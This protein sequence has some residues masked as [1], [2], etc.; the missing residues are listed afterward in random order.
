MVHYGFFID[1]L[2]R[3]YNYRLSKDYRYAVTKKWNWCTPTGTVD[4]MQSTAYGH[5]E[6]G[7]ITPSELFEN[8]MNSVEYKPLFGY[9]KKTNI[10]TG[11]I[12]TDLL[13]SSIEDYGQIACDAGS[14]TNSLYVYDAE[15]NIYK[16]ILLSM[17]GDIKRVNE[18]IY[19]HNIV[20]SFG[21]INQ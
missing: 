11:E 4:P 3:K 5:E 6:D 15:M 13:K 20:R 7:A 2:G 19:T 10:I 14:F 21:W 1:P 12:I 17:A 18:S 9:K 8:L 16:R